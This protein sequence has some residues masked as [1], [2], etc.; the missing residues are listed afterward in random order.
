[1]AVGPCSPRPTGAFPPTPVQPLPLLT[2][3]PGV[4]LVGEGGSFGPSFAG[5][6]AVAL[7]DRGPAELTEYF[8]SQLVAEGLGVD[9]GRVQMVRSPGVSGTFPVS[10]GAAASSRRCNRFSRI[11]SCYRFAYT[12]RS[13]RRTDLGPWG[14]AMAK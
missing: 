14:T 6:E 3:P 11:A 1:M 7:T 12:R 4:Q 5:S 9:G 2:A 8:A 10:S 13:E